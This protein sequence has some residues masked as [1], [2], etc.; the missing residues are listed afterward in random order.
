MFWRGVWGYLPANIVQGV[1]GL[2]T[3]VVFT[4]VL[5]PH[6]WG[7][8]TLALSVVMVTHTAFT[9]AKATKLLLLSGFGLGALSLGTAGYKYA[10]RSSKYF[11]A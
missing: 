9:L 7:E 4:R 2:L 1:V 3:I 6:Q 11:P 8:Y 10:N 5:D